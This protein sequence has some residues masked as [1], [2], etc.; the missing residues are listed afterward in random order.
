MIIDTHAHYNLDPLYQDWQNQKDKSLEKKVT[1][2]LVVGTDIDTSLRALEII[3]SDTSYFLASFGIHPEVATEI[4]ENNL[5]GDKYDQNVID[6]KI[7]E[8][9]QT[10]EKMF[11]ENIDILNK[12]IVAVGEAGMDFYRLKQKGLKRELCISAQEKIF[13]FQIKLALRH[14]L[15]LIIHARDQINRTENNAYDNI[16]NLINVYDPEK[17]LKFILHCVSGTYNYIRECIDRGAYIGV[18]GNVTYDNAPE[19]REIVKKVPLERVL[20][21]TDAPFLAPLSHKSE[22]CEPH[23]ISETAKYLVEHLSLNLDIIKENT[24][25]LFPQFNQKL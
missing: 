9:C 22:I 2:A 10:L 1:N 5:N 19:I 3:N 6:Q 7:T 18:A 11:A 15:V 13:G 14:D 23:L 20:L 17:K 24:L 4:I 16:L 21:E 25:R 12:K 8:K